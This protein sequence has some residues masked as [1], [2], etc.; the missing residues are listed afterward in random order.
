MSEDIFDFIVALLEKNGPIP[1]RKEKEKLAYRFLENGHIDSF[2]L[3]EFIMEIEDRFNIILS[4]EDM[5]SEEFRS[6]G[7]LIKIIKKCINLN[8]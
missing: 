5:Q 2:K 1:E 8:Q 6:V 4:P 3:N 7:G